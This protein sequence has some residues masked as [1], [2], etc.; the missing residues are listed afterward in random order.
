M[1][2]RNEETSDKELRKAISAIPVEIYETVKMLRVD[3]DPILGRSFFPIGRGYLGPNFPRDGVMMLGSEWG[4]EGNLK[5]LYTPN[6]DGSKREERESDP[7]WARSL[8]LIARA[9]PDRA[10]GLKE[11]AWFTN[12]AMGVRAGFGSNSDKISP[13]F[14]EVDS[15]PNEFVLRCK[16]ILELQLARQRPRAVV[17]FGKPVA[18]TLARLYPA[19]MARWRLNKFSERDLNDGAALFNVT[20]GTVAVPM[21]ASIVHPSKW[22]INVQKRRFRGLEGDAVERALFQLVDDRFR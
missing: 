11:K 12:F 8:D 22:R 4:T 16:E 6:R 1:C 3:S 7:T 20:L 5:R 9:D 19:Q 18:M 2:S 17:V 10:L 21:V 15:E 13:W 14:N